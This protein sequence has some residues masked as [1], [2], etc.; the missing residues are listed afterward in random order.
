MAEG[1]EALAAAQSTADNAD[2][3]AADAASAAQAATDTEIDFGECL[4]HM[5]APAA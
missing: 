4:I 5:E 2:K 3:A 1:Q